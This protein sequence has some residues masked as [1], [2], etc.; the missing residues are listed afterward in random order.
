MGPI[1]SSFPSVS[2]HWTFVQEEGT[3]AEHGGSTEFRRQRSEFAETEAAGSGGESARR[4]AVSWRKSSK[5][6]HRGS[7]ESLGE[8]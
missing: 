6:L 4:E 7:F 8:P 2:A 5:T 3:P 1:T